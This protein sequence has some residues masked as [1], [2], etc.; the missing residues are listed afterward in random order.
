M[1]A[2]V[3]VEISLSNAI[4]GPVRQ[5]TEAT[6]RVAGGDLDAAV[7]VRSA[8]EIGTLA[9]GL[10]PNGR[11]ASASCGV[12]TSASCWSRSRRP[13]RPSIRSTIRCWST[14]EAGRLT[15]INPAAER[16]FGARRDV[17]GKPIDEVAR[18]PRIAQAVTDVLTSQRAFASESAAAVLPWAV[19]G[20]RL[21]FRI[22]S[23]PMRDADG[24]LVGVVTLL[25]DITHLSEISRLKSEFIAAASH[26]LR[27]PLTSVQMGIHL[28]L[29]PGAEPLTD[30][31]Q[32]ILYVCRDDAA[33]LDRL[34]RELLD[35][36]K[37]RVGRGGARAGAGASRRRSLRDAVDALRLQ[38][39]A[40]GIQLDVDAAPDLPPGVRRS[41]VRS[42]ASS[43][44]WSPTRVARRR[45]GGTITVSAVPRR[46]GCRRIGHRHRQRDSARVPGEDLRTVRAG[47][48]RAGRR[49]R[50]RS[51]HLPAHRR[52]ARRSAERAVRARPGCDVHVHHPDCEARCSHENS[53]RRRRGAHPADDAADARGR[54]VTRWSKRPT[55]RRGCQRFGDGERRRRR[56]AGSEDAGHRRPRDA[57][58]N[59]RACPG[60]GRAD[61]H[62]VRVDRAGGRRDE[63][64][65]RPIFSA[66]R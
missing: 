55:A 49:R 50:A 23:T 53:D 6:T 35:L 10:Q 2:G 46:R 29:E 36:S 38:I 17:I 11:S 54:R 25:E 15:R 60:R 62:R 63:D 41:R 51:H 48:E 20:A 28:L 66:S 8:D 30:R 45:S 3:G 59:P 1:A 52:G 44:T 4:L 12:R 58:R 9:T 56:R 64:S 21:A 13:K 27:T 24:R 47:A 39:E 31:Q 5:L 33:R 14:D 65:A 22:R 26:E 16:L 37:H 7:P 43:P 57:S 32:E 34:M 42:S 18:D 40:A 19:D 61:G